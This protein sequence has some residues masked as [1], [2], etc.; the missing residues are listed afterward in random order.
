MI[1]YNRKNRLQVLKIGKNT[2]NTSEANPA[3]YGGYS[4]HAGV[5]IVFIKYWS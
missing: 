2:K 5:F 3:V 1:I 4:R